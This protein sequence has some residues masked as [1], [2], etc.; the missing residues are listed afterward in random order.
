MVNKCLE[1]SKRMDLL[2]NFKQGT[3]IFG[4]FQSGVDVYGYY[5]KGYRYVWFM[6]N[7]V[8]ICLEMSIVMQIFLGDFKQSTDIFG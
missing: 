2:G 3:D 5:Q 4:S 8:K 7:M 1:M 6:S